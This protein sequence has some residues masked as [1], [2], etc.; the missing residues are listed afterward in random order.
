[1]ST[2]PLFAIALALML[3]L[4]TGAQAQTG[5]RMPA[6]V[7]IDF[8]TVDADA[9]GVINQAEW[10]ALR[11]GTLVAGTRAARMIETHDTD[12]DGLLSVDELA[13]AGATMRENRPS[14]ERATEMAARMFTAL[15]ADADGMLSFEEFAARAQRLQGRMHDRAEGRSAG[16]ARGGDRPQRSPNRN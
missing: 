16:H 8:S 5:D 6:R 9:D 1:M 12:G 7:P 3:P 2:T 4:A 14:S 10:D 11:S 13:V 15:D